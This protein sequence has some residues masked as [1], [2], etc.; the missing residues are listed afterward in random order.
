MCIL[1]LLRHVF[2]FALMKSLYIGKIF[3]Y[4][5]Y[6]IICGHTNN[7]LLTYRHNGEKGINK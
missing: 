4:I 1:G 5:K 2:I 3:L 7:R 6:H